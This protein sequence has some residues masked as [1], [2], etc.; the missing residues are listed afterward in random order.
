MKT[1][2]Y[3]V[4]GECEQKLLN[5]IKAKPSLIKPGKV[6]VL[7]VIQERI[8]DSQL[9]SIKEG[10]VIFVFDSDVPKVEILIENINKVKSSCPAKTVKLLHLVQVPKFEYEL[11]RST[12]VRR[13]AEITGSRSNKDFKS[14]FL[15]LHD[16]RAALERKGFDINKMWRMEVPEPFNSIVSQG[17]DF[18]VKS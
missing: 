2:T 5:A 8:K 12:N 17:A 3:F 11:V 1:Y 14:D 4:E 9:I 16:C 15:A 13:A 10:Y 6:H 18:L 7:N